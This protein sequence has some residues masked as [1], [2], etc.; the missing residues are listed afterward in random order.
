MKQNTLID[1][2]RNYK[3]LK[4]EIKDIELKIEE[5]REDI[6]VAPICYEERPAPTNK[7]NSSVENDAI[8]LAEKTSE[9]EKDKRHRERE[10]ERID[11]ALSILSEKERKV[12]RLKH[13]EGYN[14]DAITYTI[15]RSY[16]SCKNMESEALRKIQRF[17]I[18]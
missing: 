4:A 18:N 17:F 10:I 7:F 6:S 16:V 8:R 14:W 3:I 9:L 2:L 5:L 1:R 11:N 12:L 15:D 13:V